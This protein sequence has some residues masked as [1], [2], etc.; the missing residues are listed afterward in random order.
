MNKSS[1]RFEHQKNIYLANEDKVQT[2][3][4]RPRWNKGQNQWVIPP[5]PLDPDFKEPTT[6]EP[7]EQS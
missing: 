4:K 5:H 3:F 2:F 6:T 7:K 1:V